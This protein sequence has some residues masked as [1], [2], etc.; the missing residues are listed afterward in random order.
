MQCIE[1][2]RFVLIRKHHI[3]WVERAPHRVK[4]APQ[5]V[6]VSDNFAASFGLR[7]K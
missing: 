3:A 2:F 1:L 7:P 5:I 6:T 4:S